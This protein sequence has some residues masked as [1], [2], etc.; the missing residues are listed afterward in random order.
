M[1]QITQNKIVKVTLNIEELKHLALIKD[2]GLTFDVNDQIIN[3]MGLSGDST[4]LVK[5]TLRTQEINGIFERFVMYKADVMS[6]SK[7]IKENSKYVYD[8]TLIIDYNISNMKVVLSDNIVANFLITYTSKSIPSLNMVEY[9][10]IDFKVYASQL[11]IIGNNQ[12]D[13][14]YF[15]FENNENGLFIKM[16]YEIGHSSITK[17]LKDF[18]SEISDYQSSTFGSEL[19]NDAVKLFGKDEIRIRTKS[20]SQERVY[21]LRLNNYWLE[22]FIAPRVMD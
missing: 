7:F 10:D 5:L 18:D 17:Q 9:P 20:T 1:S 16:G 14:T 13:F 4:T 15:R 12:D 6:L 2:R 3:V 11:K 22:Y 21:F 8:T 19:F